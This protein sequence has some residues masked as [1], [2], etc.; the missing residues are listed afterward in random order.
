METKVRL[1]KPSISQQEIDRATEILHSEFLGMGE[2]VKEFELKLE[3]F[4]GQD[5]YVATSNT[6]TSALQLALQSIGVGR[7]DEVIVP[8]ITYVASYQAISATGAIPVPCDINLS[9]GNIDCQELEKLINPKTK[10]IMPVH[11]AGD[12]KGLDKV[13]KLADYYQIRVVEDAA[14][15]FGSFFHGSKIGSI[16]DIV[17]FSFDAI[18]NI[19]TIEGGCVVSGSKEIKNKVSTLRLLAVENDS[20]NRFKGKRT[21]KSNVYGQGWRYHMGNLNAAIGLV[22]LS[23]FNSFA[24]KR[25]KIA[26]EYD[27]R[28]SIDSCPVGFFKRNYSE[29]VPH[30]YPVFI[31]NRSEASRDMLVDF[32]K[33]KGIEIGLHYFPNNKYS[34]FSSNRIF[35]ATEKFYSSILTLPLHTD[36]SEIDINYVSEMVNAFKL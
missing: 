33:S 16:G 13:Y 10:A 3:D 35:P 22:Q 9:S 5:R 1:S 8:T 29:I 4:F 11:F 17:C 23:R 31:K 36:L 14:H 12:P 2:T 15:A 24:I 20:E 28:F 6:G 32:L 19:T 34:F 27:K 18:K 25:Q 7:N 21:Y 26:K 30:I